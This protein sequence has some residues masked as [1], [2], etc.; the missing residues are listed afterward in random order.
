M[1]T[2]HK[3]GVLACL[4]S[5]SLPAWSQPSGCEAKRQEIE[6]Q[7]AAAKAKGNKARVAG[8]E[9]ALANN[10][11]HCTDASLRRDAQREVDQAREKLAERER[12]LQKARDEGRDAD[13]LAD[14]QR[15]VDEARA[16]LAR[17]QADA[18][19]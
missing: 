7:I 15:K 10:K 1:T 4:L 13:K 19:Q 11:A 17:A 8:L 5:L 16:D 14:R 6:A 9:T 18:G 3:A 2:F 12:E